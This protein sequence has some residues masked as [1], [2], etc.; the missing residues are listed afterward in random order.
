M[1]ASAWRLATAFTTVLFAI[2]RVLGLSDGE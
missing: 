2:A 1:A